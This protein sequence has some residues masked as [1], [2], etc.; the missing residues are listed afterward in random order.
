M[1]ICYK[2]NP[3]ENME[4]LDQ[5]ILKSLT[6]DKITKNCRE[7]M[8]KFH[9]ISKED[10]SRCENLKNWFKNNKIKY[11]EWSI[12]DNEVKK[13][14]LKD[15]KFLSSFCDE[16]GCIVLT[17]VLYLDESGKYYMKQLFGIDGVRGEFIKKILEI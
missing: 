1:I 6:N 9:I 12:Q 4:Y 7:F 5:D 8:K 15:P 13:R 16:N 2:L 17:P 10:C 11:E 14:L 3:Q